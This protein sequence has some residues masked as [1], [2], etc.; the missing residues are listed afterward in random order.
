MSLEVVN[1]YV[2]HSCADVSLAKKGVD[3]ARPKDGPEAAPAADAPPERAP[4]VTLG[5]APGT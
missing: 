5:G 3:P 4:A 2:C 1:G